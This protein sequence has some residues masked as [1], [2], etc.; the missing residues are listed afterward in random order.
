MKSID[1]QTSCKSAGI[2]LKKTMKN[3]HV[4]TGAYGNRKPK[5][6]SWHQNGN[7]EFW[8]SSSGD[9]DND[10]HGCFCKNIQGK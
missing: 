5:G 7:V 2:W 1:D 9:C 10:Y 8:T 6:C 4:Q 3:F